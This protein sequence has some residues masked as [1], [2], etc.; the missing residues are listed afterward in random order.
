VR[1]L[2]KRQK[3][4][5]AYLRGHLEGKGIPPSTREIQSHFGFASQ[6]AALN[7]LRALQKKGFIQRLPNKARAMRIVSS[8]STGV[9]SAARDFMEIPVVGPVVAGMPVAAEQTHA[10]YVKITPDML[11]S[12]RGQPL[13]ALQVRGDSMVEAHIV[14]GDIVVLEQRPARTGDIVA[15][16]I[17]GESTL[18]R[19]LL[20]DG[21]PFLRAENP[22]YPDLIPAID[23][24]IQGVMI[25]LVRRPVA[26]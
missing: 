21:R 8:L 20:Q 25:A 17:D 24:V 15:A 13:F 16:L 5:L 7:H 14:E 18:K 3:E 6:T 9:V 10:G 2:T 1:A 23:L 22:V 11:G 26:A 19:F 12:H 4:V